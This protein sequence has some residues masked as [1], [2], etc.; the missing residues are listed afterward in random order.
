[1]KCRLCGCENLTILTEELRRGRG[2]VYF[3]HKCKYGM[4]EPKFKDASE[5]YDTEYRKFFKNNLKEEKKESPKSIYNM[6]K[7]YQSDRIRII[8]DFFDDEKSFLEIGSSAGQFLFHIYDKFKNVYGIEL[9]KSCAEYCRDLLLDVGCATSKIYSNSIES[10]KWREDQVFDYIGFFQ[11]LEHITDPIFFLQCVHD[12][13]LD[14]G[15][16]FIEVPNL[17]DPLL[18]I[19]DV[20]AY[21]KFYYHEAHLSYFTEESL[22]ILLE[23]CGFIIE[24]MYFLQDYNFLNNLYWYFNNAP[25]DSCEFGLNRPYLEFKQEDIG[26]EIND[27][28]LRMNKDYFEILSKHKMTSN[29]FVVAKKV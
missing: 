11:V 2:K 21:E 23:K 29:I 3:C 7:D 10:I 9:D 16:V 13:L 18:R 1:M 8:S 28:L 27:L 6:Q 5:Y 12:R 22:K 20:P 26:R 14:G 17:D 15:R 19:W 25:Q 24:S 4:L